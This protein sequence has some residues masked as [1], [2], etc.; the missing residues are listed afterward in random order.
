[1]N[2]DQDTRRSPSTSALPNRIEPDLETGVVFASSPFNGPGADIILRTS[3]DVDFGAHMSILR[4]ASPVFDT[5][6]SLPQPYT[7]RTESATVPTV[8][9]SESS[10]TLDLLLRICY[11]IDPPLLGQQDLSRIGD[12]LGAALKYDI[13]AVVGPA[14]RALQKRAELSSKDA[15]MAYAI[16]CHLKLEDEARVAAMACLKWPFPGPIVPQLA[17]MSGLDYYN[18]LE[19]H[20]RCGSAIS[21]LFQKN[22]YNFVVETCSAI[23]PPRHSCSSITHLSYTLNNESIEVAEYE[24]WAVAKATLAEELKRAPLAIESLSL[25][26]LAPSLETSECHICKNAFLRGWDKA[27]EAIIAAINKKIGKVCRQESLC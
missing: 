11:P 25:S 3:D 4:L 6:F 13:G 2:N 22:R 9:V 23:T 5:M 21:S 18:L 17:L 27:R 24:W 12:V 19:Y 8:P 20:R 16:S 14:R 1:M 15:A 26:S 7:D 10:A